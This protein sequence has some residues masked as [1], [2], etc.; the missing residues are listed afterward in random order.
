MTETELVMQGVEAETWT[1]T[2]SK[3]KSSLS[4]TKVTCRRQK[5]LHE[6]FRFDYSLQSPAKV[7]SYV[8]LRDNR[9]RHQ[10][11]ATIWLEYRKSQCGNATRH[12]PKNRPELR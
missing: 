6:N 11:S 8:F 1:N 9:S 4:K 10:V 7:F 12:Q 5:V 2:L 3:A